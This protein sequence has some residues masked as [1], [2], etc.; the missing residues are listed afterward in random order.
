M[1]SCQESGVGV[2]RKVLQNQ[3]QSESN[4]E[5]RTFRGGS[6]CGLVRVG[7]HS[8]PPGQLQLP[9]HDRLVEAVAAR[10]R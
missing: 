6:D 7:L 9:S 10:L 5:L 1:T 8:C 2:R 4:K 3:A